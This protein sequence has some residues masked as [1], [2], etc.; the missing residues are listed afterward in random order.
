MAT[1][2]IKINLENIYN[3]IVRAYVICKEWKYVSEN[4][5][6]V[7]LP[8]MCFKEHTGCLTVKPSLKYTGTNLMKWEA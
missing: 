7:C 8:L 3:L 6:T 5:A 2:S 4:H 1:L